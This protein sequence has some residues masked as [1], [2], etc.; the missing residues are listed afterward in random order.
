MPKVPHLG[1]KRR[2]GAV[3]LGHVV[4]HF[5]PQAPYH[6]GPIHTL[7]PFCCGGGG[8]ALLGVRDGRVRHLHCE[9]QS[10]PG[11]HHPHGMP[12][13]DVVDRVDVE[14]NHEGVAEGE[15]PVAG[16]ERR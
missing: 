1:R 16:V 14:V 5:V 11:V 7:S 13:L 8:G 4:T 9:P 6:H 10:H 12:A 3:T 2:V 15:A